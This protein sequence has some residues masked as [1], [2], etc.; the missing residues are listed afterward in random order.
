MPHETEVLALVDRAQRHRVPRIIGERP[1]G[2]DVGE[3]TVARLTGD[4]GEQSLAA[5]DSARVT[6]AAAA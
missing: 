5:G 2:R 4:E 3:R 6:S 1:V